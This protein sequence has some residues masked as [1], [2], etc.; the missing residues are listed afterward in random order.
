MPIISLGDLTIF[1]LT[2]ASIVAFV[3]V[4]RYFM[5]QAECEEARAQDD[6]PSNPGSRSVSRPH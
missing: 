3:L 4:L 2:V 1:L 6:P 5:K